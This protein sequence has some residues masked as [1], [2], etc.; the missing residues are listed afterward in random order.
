MT[1]D[2]MIEYARILNDEDLE[3]TDPRFGAVVARQL[4]NEVYREVVRDCRTFR[5]TGTITTAG[6]TREYSLPTGISIVERVEWLPSGE[7]IGRKLIIC[8]FNRIMAAQGP[9]EGYYLKGSY[10]GVDPVPDGIYTLNLWGYGEPSADLGENDPLDMI[11]E[12]WRKVVSY[13]LVAKFKEIDKGLDSNE[14]RKWA[15]IATQRKAELRRFL[16]GGNSAD[17]KPGVG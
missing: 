12:A 13:C 10:L 9:P 15:G 11:P 16:H 3:D 2:E 1:L 17:H 4:G 6:G 5:A 14:Y 8:R 7:T